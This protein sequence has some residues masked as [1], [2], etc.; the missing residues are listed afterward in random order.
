[1]ATN[2]Q[3]GSAHIRNEFLYETLTI[4]HRFHPRYQLKSFTHKYWSPHTSPLTSHSQSPVREREKEYAIWKFFAEGTVSNSP[5][6]YSIQVQLV[7]HLIVLQIDRLKNGP[8]KGQC[9]AGRCETDAP[10]V[11]HLSH[12]GDDWTTWMI[13]IYIK[14]CILLHAT[15]NE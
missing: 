1:M 4:T 6:S 2:V 7:W 3:Q 11:S 15:H 12:H 14:H 10:P 8:A 9:A 5:F 13:Y